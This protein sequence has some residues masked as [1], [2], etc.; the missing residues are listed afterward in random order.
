MLCYYPLKK[1]EIFHDKS[2]CFETFRDFLPLDGIDPALTLGEGNTPL[3]KLNRI[4]QH[5]GYSGLYAKNECQNPT[6]SFKDRGTAVAIQKAKSMNIKHI[7]TVSTGNMAS[8]T[9]AYS[10]KAGLT[11]VVLVKADITDEK[12][13]SSGIYG[14]VLIKV[15]GDYGTLMAQSSILGKNHSIY[16]MNSVD[17]FRIEGYKTIGFETFLQLSSNAP[18]YMIVPVSSGG[19]LIG[20]M[21]AFL[22]LKRAGYISEIP[23]CIGVQAHGCAPIAKAFAIGKTK[24]QRIKRAKTIAQAITNPDPPGGNLLLKMLREHKGRMIAVSDREIQEAQALLAREEG[25]FCLPASAAVLAAFLKLAKT[26]LFQDKDKI[27][28]VLTGTGLKDIKAL[29]SQEMNLHSS[30]LAKLDATVLANLD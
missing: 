12:L 5:L 24:V 10:A 23:Q 4:G 19:H 27:V 26:N 15:R 18:Q 7:G 3:I 30:T 1:R 29:K 17:P 9:A 6:G 2:N 20:L 28:L 11:S 14:P 21:K 25:L 22:E 13:F 16:F 8:S